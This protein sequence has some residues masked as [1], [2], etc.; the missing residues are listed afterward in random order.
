MGIEQSCWCP[1]T[2]LCCLRL[3][4]NTPG[5]EVLDEKVHASFKTQHNGIAGHIFQIGTE[6]PFHLSHFLGKLAI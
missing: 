5:L 2:W 4:A 1:K 6:L 3:Q